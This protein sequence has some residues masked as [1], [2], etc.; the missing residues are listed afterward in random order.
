M[1]TRG[2]K[3]KAK[4]DPEL[5]AAA[6]ELGDLWPERLNADPSAL[7]AQGKHDVYRKKSCNS[8]TP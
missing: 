6:R 1:G 5:V 4:A 3:P 7:S 2:C 8:L